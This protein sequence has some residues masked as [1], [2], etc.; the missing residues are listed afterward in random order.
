MR[1]FFSCSF[2][3]LSDTLIP[4]SLNAVP[5]HAENWPWCTFVPPSV[6]K[7][8]G[9][10]LTSL[11]LDGG[12]NAGSCS[13]CLY[14][15]VEVTIVCSFL[16][17]STCHQPVSNRA[18][19]L[20]PSSGKRRSQSHQHIMQLERAVPAATFLP[21]SVL[22]GEN[23]GLARSCRCWSRSEFGDFLQQLCR[24]V[25]WQS[26]TMHDSC[27][28]ASGDFG[29]SNSSLPL[30]CLCA[31]LYQSIS[32]AVIR[33]LGYFLGLPA[34]LTR[35]RTPKE[36]ARLYQVKVGGPWG[37]N[38]TEEFRQFF[39]RFCPAASGEVAST[40]HDILFPCREESLLRIWSD[41]KG[42]ME[43]EVCRVLPLCKKEKWI[44]GRVFLMP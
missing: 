29:K 18:G 37:G 28:T 14:H 3:S 26:R 15:C 4:L 39:F 1:S 43:I 33:N 38:P 27:P 11:T 42:S 22:W 8:L 12:V 16:R 32:R 23:G 13:V 19:E 41:K 9:D 34:R 21:S 36:C 44:C 24:L 35:G 20:Y 25:V 17:L 40:P 30:L 7:L 6:T 10:H 5:C 2:S 31:V